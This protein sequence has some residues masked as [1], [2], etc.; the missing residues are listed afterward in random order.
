MKVMNDTVYSLRY[1]IPC[2]MQLEVGWFLASHAWT[3]F[4]SYLQV[5][6]LLTLVFTKFTYQKVKHV[7]SENVFPQKATSV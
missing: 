7:L 3:S 4:V 2:Y 5:Q 1:I 6:Y